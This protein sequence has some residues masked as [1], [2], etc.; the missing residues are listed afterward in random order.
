MCCH[1]LDLSSNNVVVIIIIVVVVVVVVGGGG[2][3]WSHCR[4]PRKF[5]LG[6][7][8]CERTVLTIFKIRLKS[9]RGLPLR[10]H[11]SPSSFCFPRVFHILFVLLIDPRSQDVQPLQILL[12]LSLSFC[13]TS[14]GQWFPC[15]WMYNEMCKDEMGVSEKEKICLLV[16]TFS[17]VDLSLCANVKK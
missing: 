10:L 12:H 16:V 17:L 9:I 8:D 3:H 7:P 2:A 1:M 15:I 6:D 11:H 4:P 13:E 14:P 5:F